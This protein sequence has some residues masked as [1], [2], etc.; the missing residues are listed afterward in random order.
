MLKRVI[1]VCIACTLLLNVFG[2]TSLSRISRYQLRSTTGGIEGKVSIITR[3][4][5]R[6]DMDRYAPGT[7]TPATKISADT[8]YSY[9][10]EQC[11]QIPMFEIREIS[12]RKFS[13]IK[14]LL[15]GG[16]VLLTV[17]SIAFVQGALGPW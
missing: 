1:T 3:T 11:V 8:L 6:I 13:L 15:A 14:T 17:G 2:C 10:S 7:I 4:G 16:I 5:D 9:S 12:V